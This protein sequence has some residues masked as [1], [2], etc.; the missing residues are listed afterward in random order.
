MSSAAPG[1]MRRVLG[2]DPLRAA[3]VGVGAIG[4]LHARVYKEH[5]STKLVAVVDTRP[6]RARE[7]GEQ[8]GVDWYDDLDEMLSHE[9]VEL[10]SVATPEQERRAA[11]VACARAGA[12]LLLEKPLAPTLAETDRLISEI[13]SAG[14]TATVN[15]ILRSDPRYL[16]AKAAMTD[17]T[18]GEPCTIFARR[19]LTAETAET[20]GPW[21]QLLITVAIHDLDVMV[22]LNDC[23]VERVF[24]EGVVRRCGEW[25]HE[26][27]VLAVL[28]FANGSAG[29]LETSWVLPATAPARLDVSLHV[30]G[31]AGAVF[32]DGANHGLELLGAAGSTLP[33]MAHWPIGPTGVSGDLRAHI[34]RFVTALQS[35]RPPAVSLAEARY[36][37]ELV[38]ALKASIRSGT[39]VALPYA[40]EP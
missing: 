9:R 11:A 16:R 14:V 32:V 22:W 38:A 30:V 35:G 25:G 6:E 40:P 23:P 15:F 5:R 24:A 37:Q 39:P 31:T 19:R 1:K 2:S 18:I 21:T 29:A 20:H 34:D 17:G 36:A 8:L 27:A 13:E 26:D 4:A 33:D 12:H 10:V 7:V 3:V 28:R